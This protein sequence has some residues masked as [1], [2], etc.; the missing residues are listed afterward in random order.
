MDHATPNLPSRDF[1]LTEHFYAQLGFE[2]EWRDDGWLILSRGGMTLEFFLHPDLEPATS[3]FSC[4]LRIDD[5]DA[6]IDQAASA[7]IAED[8][9]GAPRLH[10]PKVEPSGERIGY[11]IDLDGSLLRLVANPPA[12]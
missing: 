10:R 3:W 4:C 6:L 11:L 7:G 1:D 12:I 2:R 5:L 9:E 8:I